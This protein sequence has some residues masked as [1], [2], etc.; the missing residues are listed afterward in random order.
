M[1]SGLVGCFGGTLATNG[2]SSERGNRREK[3]VT[4]WMDE[5]R[6]GAKYAQGPIGHLLLQGERLSQPQNLS[7]M[8][9]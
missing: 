2:R 1:L 5:Q 9:A 7:C 3:A 6:G 8:P 4:G